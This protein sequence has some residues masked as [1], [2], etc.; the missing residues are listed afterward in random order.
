MTRIAITGAAGF[1][2]SHVAERLVSDGHDVVGVD[3]FT[4]NYARES[5][6]C[7]LAALAA[8]PAFELVESRID[9]PAAG[10]A[11]R[12]CEAI[13]HLAAQPGVRSTDIAELW[14][15]NVTALAGMLALLPG[16]GVRRMVLASSSSIYG[17]AAQPRSEDDE[18]APSSAYAR[19]KLAAERLCAV[20]GLN[21]VT[22]RY[23]TVYGERQRPDMAFARF[24]DATLA[25]DAAPL[26]AAGKQI[27]HFTYVADAV[28]ATVRALHDAPAGAVYN[29]AS[30]T[31]AT[32][33]DAIGII[34]RYLG[35]PI[36]T[37]SLPRQPQDADAI[38]ADVSRALRQL[39]WSAKTSLADGLRAQVNAT[40]E[41]FADG[42]RGAAPP[43]R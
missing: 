31:A 20:S 42:R 43:T 33:A 16:S 6:Q 41:R 38:R 5:K 26:Y 40:V 2:G 32:V 1:I 13:I 35:R 7:N 9:S 19:S 34:E 11:F 10:R 3:C 12:D 28:E 29:V 39:G 14:Q 23:F 30:P 24:I 17:P 4:D 21:C 36:P 8:T 27:R 22:L 18:L 15:M 37:R 25:D